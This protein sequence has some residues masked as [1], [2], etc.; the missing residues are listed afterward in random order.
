MT[1]PECSSH[2]TVSRGHDKGSDEDLV[3][4][5]D[6]GAMHDEMDFRP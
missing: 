5:L 6:C 4:C 3:E 2:N 1:C